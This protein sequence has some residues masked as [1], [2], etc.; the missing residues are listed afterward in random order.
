MAKTATPLA[1]KKSITIR[2]RKLIEGVIA[3]KTKR[4][5]AIDAG[6]QGKTPEVISVAASNVLK[7]SNV[8]DALQEALEAHG[9]T[10]YKIV[11]VVADGMKADKVVI[12]GKDE[13]AFADV[14]PDHSIR[15]KAAGMAAQFM[16]IGKHENGISINFISHANEQRESYD[17]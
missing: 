1:K 2:E 6:Y 9:L 16:G 11:A 13:E 15:L 8:Q 17:L 5:A 14:V 3:G 7:K 10:P 4:Q 12:T